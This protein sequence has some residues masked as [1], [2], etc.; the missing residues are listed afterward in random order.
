MENIRGSNLFAGIDNKESKLQRNI[1]DQ[2]AFLLTIIDNHGNFMHA[3]LKQNMRSD[4]TF[5][6]KIQINFEIKF[7]NQQIVILQYNKEKISIF[8]FS[9]LYNNIIYKLY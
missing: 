5:S 7:S 6:A 4:F 3:R 9:I 2:E 8:M 1:V